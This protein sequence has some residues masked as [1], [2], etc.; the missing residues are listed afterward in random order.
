MKYQIFI[1]SLIFSIFFCVQVSE[2]QIP[3]AY[4]HYLIKDSVLS[5]GLIYKFYNMGNQRTKFSVHV[6]EAEL[7][8]TNIEPVI[9]KAR[10]HALELDK[11]HDIIQHADTSNLGRIAAAV[12]GSFW[13]AYTNNPIG[14]CF[15][16]GEIVELNPY[17]EWS[18][19]YFDAIGKPYINNFKITGKI[20]L[21][22]GNEIILN[23]LNRRRDSMEI[24]LYNRFGGS[25]VPHVSTKKLDDELATRLALAMNEFFENDSTEFEI[26][27]D[28]L[29]QELLNEKRASS[30]EN[31]LIKC[32][33]LYLD[34]P[35]V[36]R[37][38]RS[39]VTKIDTGVVTIDENSAVL[40]YGVGIPFD[41]FPNL[42]DTLLLSYTTNYDSHIEFFNGLTATPRLVRNSNARHEAIAEG[43]KG[44]RF[45]SHQLPRTAIGY[46]K[47]KS[48]LYFVTVQGSSKSLRIK[49]ANLTDMA[50]IMKSLG[51]YDALNLDGGGS[52][53][54]I[55]GGRNVMNEHRPDTSRHISVGIGIR[56]K[57]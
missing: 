36:N 53:V 16:D 7:N 4:K 46:N 47:D 22:N 54:M 48:K 41:L 32:K 31:S 28:K 52:S 21:L 20:E 38:I 43:S 13:R 19:I 50:I 14:A 25:E 10:S 15:I 11:L 57:E 51:C 18:G 2:A 39:V 29:R 56:I 30:L 35:A 5:E 17:K 45:I 6:L 26:S 23:K 1:S 34:S 9:M 37:V 33:L 8:I 49:G 44:R 24:V 3:A 27:P 40:S 42:G 12:N 55:I